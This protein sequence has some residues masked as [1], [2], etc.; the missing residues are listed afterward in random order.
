MAA[1]LS[2]KLRS[3]VKAYAP[4]PMR[5]IV[6]RVRAAMA[7]PPIDNHVGS[8]YTLQ[9]DDTGRARLTLVVPNLSPG[10]TFGGVLTGIDI[11]LTM[12]RGL[13]ESRTVDVRVIAT[14]ANATTDFGVFLKAAEKR[15]FDPAS[16]ET[17]AIPQRDHDIAVRRDDVFVTFNFWTTL[18]IEPLLD[19]QASAFSRARLPLIYL[20]QEYEPHLFPFSSAHMLVRSAYDTP[21]KLWGIFNSSNL[22]EFFRLSGHQV[23]RNYTFEP[24]VNGSLRPYLDRVGSSARQQR[25]LI[26]G[27]PAISRNCFPALQRGLREWARSYPQYR[28][29]DVVSAGKAHSAFALGDGREVRSLGKL[30]LDAYADTLL[31]AS[32]GVSLMASPH[33]SY[34]PLEMAHMGLRT[35]TNTYLCKDWKGYHPNII[36]VNSLD[37]TSLAAA[38]A[39]ACEA[40]RASDPT[41]EPNPDYVRGDEYPFM[42]EL[43]GDIA[44]ALA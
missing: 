2:A 38:I 44:N 3:A 42:G 30:S 19:A 15:G 28:D 40:S 36:A 26:Y 35:V 16:I 10:S 31:G 32:V 18:N 25:I 12:V 21:Q 7:P 5:G 20:I 23:E 22:Y 27:R 1:D 17:L 4:A 37:A 34:P 41:G 24:V 33:P 43:V 8:T 13:A 11:F 9:R 6:E 14:D 39:A 29:W